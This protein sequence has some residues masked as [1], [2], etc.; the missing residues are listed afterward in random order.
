MNPDWTPDPLDD[1][2]D[3]RWLGALDDDQPAPAPVDEAEVDRLLRWLRRL[4]REAV[5][6]H[7]RFDPEIERITARR[8]DLLA[9]V[10]AEADRIRAG[11]EHW[12]REQRAAGV[13][14][15]ELPHGTIATR[16]G[17]ERVDVVDETAAVAW[18]EI[19]LRDAVRVKRSIDK[20]VVLAHVTAT[21]EVPPGVEVHRG[22]P[23]VTIR[24]AQA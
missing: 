9:G 17:R 3:P 11:L 10:T 6:I 12:A 19:E 22:D 5:A 15:I 14:S 2:P 13:K 1:E 7:A 24:P 18:A 16:A 20:A 23:S 21:G 8:D 4:D